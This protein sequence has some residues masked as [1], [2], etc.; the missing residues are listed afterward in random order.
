MTPWR[1]NDCKHICT[2]PPRKGILLVCPLCGG[3]VFNV[4]HTR[5][6]Q[7][8]LEK[9]Q[10]PVPQSISSTYLDR[11]INFLPPERK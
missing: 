7:E 11:R 4:T 9:N 2:D 10:R 1:C 8:F 5:V 6:G 3:L